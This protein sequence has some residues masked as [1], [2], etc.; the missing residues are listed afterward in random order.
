M[1]T[2][3]VVCPECESALE[4]GRFS[5]PTCGALVAAVASVPRSFAPAPE[6][7]PPVVEAAT[8]AAP[9]APLETYA[10]EATEAEP[11]DDGWD[12]PAL[13]A[14]DPEPEPEG[15]PELPSLP[16]APARP[17]PSLA[18][19]PTAAAAYT[20]AS[21]AYAP[22]ST[23]TLAPPAPATAA[24]APAAV[25]AP[26]PPATSWPEP[27]AAPTVP[28]W[29]SQVV[30]AEP[31]PDSMPP[32]QPIAPAPSWPEQ[33]VMPV[34]EATSWPEQPVMPD[35]P[36][37][38]QAPSW[39]G[40]PAWPPMQ[41]AVV[42]AEPALRTPAGA[43]L[44]PSAVLP[45]AEAL[46]VPGRNGTA[47]AGPEATA[48]PK[49]KTLAE[50]F[51]LGDADGPLG[52]PVNAAGRTIALGA[53]IAGLG[54]LLPWAEIVIGTTS[55]G[56]FL[57]MWG[58][59]GPGHPIV[60][61]LLIAVGFL[62]VAHEKWPV[63]VGAGT[64][65]IVLGSLLLGLAFPYVMGPFREAVGVYVTAAGAVVMIAGG[66]LARVPPRHSDAEASV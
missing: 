8:A 29:P 2:K 64:A 11:L 40:Q 39:P 14:A 44:P 43:Y 5:C 61:L 53:A 15:A 3:V 59:A 27:P 45:P 58:L 41:A 50:R 30:V 63:R 22:A 13:V 19:T 55:M 46:P 47:S 66:M 34:A 65:S 32:E 1:A 26:A 35:A 21:P 25:Y 48:A 6:A 38:A 56:G 62:A 28:A 20:T 52:L 60:L 24:A 23:Y 57:D 31:E 49:S 17:A 9:A 7:M 51:A 10:H 16:V 36:P 37:A 33:P 42:A 54:F 12:P 4:P 18:A